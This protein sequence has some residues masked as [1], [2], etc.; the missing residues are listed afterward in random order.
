MQWICR[1]AF[2]TKDANGNVTSTVSGTAK[3]TLTDAEA[4]TYTYENV[5]FRSGDAWD[6]RMMAEAPDKPS[7]VSVNSSTL[8][9]DNVA[10]S[11]L[12]IVFR[13]NNVLG[14]T[15]SNQYTDATATAGQTYSYAIQAVGEYGALSTISEP[16]QVL[17][18]T[19]IQV[20]VRKVNNAAVVSWSTRTE[21]NTSH[22][23]VERSS[24]DAAFKI[25]GKTSAVGNSTST[26]RYSYQDVLQFSGDVYYR[27]KAV[28]F[29]GKYTYSPIV[30]LKGDEQA[31][32]LYP[33]VATS[34]IQVVH[35]KTA[36]TILV[37]GLTGQLLKSVSA[38]SNSGQTSLNVVSL[39]PGMYLVKFK[40]S[41]ETLNAKFIK[42]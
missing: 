39:T 21:N 7:N 33:T 6:P 13:D 28:D 4:A 27:I 32:Y 42:Q 15:T 25:I 35:P 23:E 26:N 19:G 9:W 5:I 34:S 24:A 3:N 20:A 18:V 10:Y 17:P 38:E 2:R 22:F 30:I 1:S 29:D 37:Y 11:R 14:F 31:F 36:G 16:A 12:Y 41:T 40:N 8:S